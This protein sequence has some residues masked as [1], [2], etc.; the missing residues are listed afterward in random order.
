MLDRESTFADSEIVNLLKTR[1]VPVAIDQANQ[2]RQQ[3]TEGDFYRKI[4]GQGPRSDFNGTTQGFYIATAAGKLLLYNNNRDPAKVR[5]LM[6]E[7][8][9]EFESSDAARASTAAIKTT[10][11]DER[12]N[13]RLPEG[14]L[15]LRVQAKVLD[16][17]EP[18]TNRWQSIFQSA[19]S[20]DNLWISASEHQELVRGQVPRSL[21]ERIARFHL[22][23]N[24]R[25]EPPM[26]KKEEIR[27]MD[28]QLR[29][30][31]ITGV[32]HLNTAREDRGY[33]TQLLGVVDVKNG[34]IVRFDMVSKGDFWG[35]GA[36]TGGAPNGKFPLAISFTLA[37]GTDIAD[38]L[39]P[40]G[41]RG[42][43][44]GYLR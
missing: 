43:L 35:A 37:D 33:E 39:P 14:G 28:M 40:Q 19:M 25:G 8:L 23:D 6:K 42:W 38:D 7:K 26:W 18:T 1:F 2:R 36:Y 29:N 15:V 5:R 12:Y 10:K 31:R 17:Y 11:V 21:Q 20:R 22:V 3:D 30:G 4:A 16:G 27:R 24:T 41:S 44:R 32:A 13:A 34:T 9:A